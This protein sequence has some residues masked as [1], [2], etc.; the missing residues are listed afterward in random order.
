[1]KKNLKKLIAI[2]LTGAMAMSMV[3]CG[4]SG[5]S[6]PAADTSTVEDE[7]G[8]GNGRRTCNPGGGIDF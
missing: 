5:S 7:R 2:C 1:M 3:A 6:E 8:G 4:N